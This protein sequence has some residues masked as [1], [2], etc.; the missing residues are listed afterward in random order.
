MKQLETTIITLILICFVFFSEQAHILP[1]DAGKWEQYYPQHTRLLD[2]LG[3]YCS[4]IFYYKS[5]SLEMMSTPLTIHWV[6]VY[7]RLL[8][9]MNPSRPHQLIDG[10][11]LEGRPVCALSIR[12]T[13]SM[14]VWEDCR[15]TLQ[16]KI[17][18]GNLS[19]KKIVIKY[20]VRLFLPWKREDSACWTEAKVREEKQEEKEPKSPERK[21]VI[22][23]CWKCSK[24]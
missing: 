4:S 14:T 20:T 10:S 9:S 17:R 16:R 2:S 18:V 11:W 8:L 1:G 3:D 24:M 5:H 6:G 22:K 12:Q 15:G 23:K 21:H 19:K 13:G 7:R